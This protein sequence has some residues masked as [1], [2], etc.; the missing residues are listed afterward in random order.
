[1]L[2]GVSGHAGLFSSASDLVKLFEM[3]LEKGSIHQL[4]FFS[5]ETI[6]AF[7]NSISSKSDR[8]L[9]WDK[10]PADGESNYISASVSPSSYGHSGYTGTLVWA[11]PEKELVFIFLSNR[12]HPSASNNKINALKIRRKVMD[13]VYKSI[14]KQQ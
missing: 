3:N 1:M 9:G 11:D 13:V 7:T 8:A 2:G 10:L 4:K 14:E 5:E 6:N 12:V